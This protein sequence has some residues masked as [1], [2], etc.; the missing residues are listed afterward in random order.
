MRVGP[1]A[2]AGANPSTQASADAFVK[3][4]AALQH[5][6]GA[7]ALRRISRT[8]RLVLALLVGLVAVTLV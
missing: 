1:G 3:K 8:V 2:R 5:L 6:L 7:A 4:Q